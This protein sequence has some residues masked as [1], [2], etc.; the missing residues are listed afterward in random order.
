MPGVRHT[1]FST[2]HRCTRS[3]TIR[4]RISIPPI[5]KHRMRS[6]TNASMYSDC[7]A[8]AERMNVPVKNWKDEFKSCFK[9][10]EN[11]DWANQTWVSKTISILMVPFYIGG[12]WTI[13]QLPIN[14][15][16]RQAVWNKPLAM[17]QAF[18]VPIVFCV[19]LY[20]YRMPAFGPLPRIALSVIIGF[21]LSLLVGLTTDLQKPPKYWCI[22]PFVGFGT[23]MLW[24]YIEANEIL[25]ILTA[26]GTFWNVSNAVMGLTFLGWANNVGDFVADLT[27]AKEGQSR[28]AFSAAFAGPPLYLLASV[29]LA[30]FVT[31]AA[32][33][34]TDIPINIQNVEIVL[35]ICVIVCAMASLL[36]LVFRRFHA[37]R[38]VAICLIV[39]YLFAFVISLL[40]GLEILW[41]P[42][43]S[44]PSSSQQ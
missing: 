20:Q 15:D 19:F 44:S 33:G 3:G 16:K 1:G 30:C 2:R 38:F 34:F 39:A 11:D 31:S 9:L 28:C 43:A 35:F 36:P 42:T 5:S 41:P 12:R 24:I 37:D 4:S 22:F 40:T 6:L 18:L 10:L 14:N 8:V 25:N 27:I 26:L 23:G 32:N 21:G 13:P 29:G 17:I 7:Q